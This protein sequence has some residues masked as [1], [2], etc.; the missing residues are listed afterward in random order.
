MYLGLVVLCVHVPRVGSI[1]CTCICLFNVLK[2]LYLYIT[3]FMITFLLKYWERI[4]DET[5][6][7]ILHASWDSW[8]VNLI[9][10]PYL[11]G[12]MS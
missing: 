11:D 6:S 2:V 9:F 1:V 3:E 8:R 5:L 4:G 10:S 7:T 12:D